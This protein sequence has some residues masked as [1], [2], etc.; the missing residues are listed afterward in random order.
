MRKEGDLPPVATAFGLLALGALLNALLTWATLL[1]RQDSG[2][3]VLFVYPVVAIVYGLP[4]V[5]RYRSSAYFRQVACYFVAQLP[6]I[7]FVAV[8]VTMIAGIMTYSESDGNGL[9]DWADPIY[10]AAVGSVLAL[11]VL[12]RR[13]FTADSRYKIV[14]A[15][16]GAIALVSAIATPLVVA[17]YW[18]QSNYLSGVPQDQLVKAIGFPLLWQMVFAF[19]AALLLRR[20]EEAT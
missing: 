13:P 7:Y 15:I 8:V 1:L 3:Q 9:R 10:G 12:T 16:G 20:R 19:V 14:I 2:V 6:A 17:R 11:V 18:S 5:V 4:L